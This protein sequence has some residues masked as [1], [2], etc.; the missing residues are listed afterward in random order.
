METK[1]CT[2]CGEEKDINEFSWSIAG[3]KRHARCKRCRAEER[4]EYYEKNKEKDLEYKWERQVKKR[5][6]ARLYV[7]SYLATHPC[8][9]ILPDG[10]RCPQSDPRVLTFHHVR[11]VKKNNV[12]QMVNQGYS[13]KAI[14]EEIDKCIILCG[15]C[16]MLEEKR[17]RGTKYPDL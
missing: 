14:Q 6:V 7:F 16:H 4:S 13:L 11:G 3:I 8:E 15:N 9:G 2:G 5:E 17:I 10:S 1:V 12:S